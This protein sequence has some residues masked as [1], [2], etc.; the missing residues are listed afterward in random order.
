MARFQYQAWAEPPPQ[1]TGAP[2]A[3]H[4]DAWARR[5][6]EP[7]RKHPPREP[8]LW[9]GVTEPSL[10]VEPALESWHRQQS[11][12]QRGQY[13][14]QQFGST[15]SAWELWATPALEPYDPAGSI[16]R[17]Q[18]PDP[19]RLRA[20]T[21]W[22]WYAAPDWSLFTETI[23]VDKWFQPAS[24]PRFTKTP[25]RFL[26]GLFR[27]LEPSLITTPPELSWFQPASEPV[28][29]APPLRTSQWTVWPAHE[30]IP[31]VVVPDFFGIPISQP[32]FRAR[33]VVPQRWIVEPPPQLFGVDKLFVQ[34]VK[35]PDTRLRLHTDLVAEILNSLIRQGILV[36]SGQGEWTIELP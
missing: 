34:R 5:Q 18:Q 23:T 25:L 28:R 30:I 14:Q 6:S 24:E 1:A 33:P 8:G 22:T 11:E 19:V 2:E 10:F 27:P 31:P 17:L 13:R 20:R 29:K 4:P 9:V 7:V 3:V 26:G 12:P 21:P 35:T 36:H 15:Y 32:L 16:F